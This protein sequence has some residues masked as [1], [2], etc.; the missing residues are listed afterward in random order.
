MTGK[1]L[2]PFDHH[3][4]ERLLGADVLVDETLDT[5]NELV[6]GK[7][8]DLDV[9]DRGF[10][11]TSMLLGAGLDLAEAPLRALDGGLES[12]DLGGDRVVGNLDERDIRHFPQQKVN[13]ADDDTR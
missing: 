3:E 2:P 9:E 12:L 1:V 13:G 6:V 5:M 10:L 4:I 11:G 7:N 8:R